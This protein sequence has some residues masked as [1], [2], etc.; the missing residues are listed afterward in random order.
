MKKVFVLLAVS[1]FILMNFTSCKSKGSSTGNSSATGWKYNDSKNGGFEKIAYKGQDL[2]PGLVFVEG[3]SFMM[4]QKEQDVMFEWNAVPRKVTV[5]SF[6]MDETEVANIHYKEY[7]YWLQRVFGESFPQVVNK[8]LPDTLVWRDEL[9]YNEPYLE[10]YFRHPSYDMYPVVGVNWLQANDFAKWRTDR[11]NEGILVKKGIL[12]LDPASDVDENNF[13]TGAYLAGQYEGNVK[14]NLKDL[15]PN[16]SGERPVK[17]EDGILQPDYRLPTEAEWEFAAYSLR[18]NLPYK[19]EERFTDQKI[20]PWNGFSLRYPKSGKLQGKFLANFKRGRGDNMGIAGNLNDDGAITTEVKA[21]F[22]NDYGLYNMAG[23]VNEWVMDVYRPMTSID[24]N[25]FNSFRGNIFK[26]KLKSEDGTELAEKD[27]LGR[28][29]YRDVTNE[30]AAERRNYRKSDVRNYIDQDEQ[31][32]VAYQY[33]SSSLINDKSRVYKGGSWKDRAYWM[34]PGSR[35]FIQEYESTDD[36]GFRCAM[37][38]VGSPRGNKFKS[39]NH[40]GGKKK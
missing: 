15:N 38:R 7:L 18:G 32:L 9:A 23:N 20:Y 27:S 31:S 8:A 16:G 36:I 33:G 35:R 3:G 24:A 10:Y 30:E 19:D 37:D 2:A 26:T 21:Y 14:K 17:F 39:G 40:F 28:L 5:N 34:S 25:D 4:G 29:N 13:N 12:N 22:P 1:S 6:Y 11:V